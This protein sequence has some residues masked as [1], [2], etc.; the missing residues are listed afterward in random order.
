MSVDASHQNRYD[1]FADQYAQYVADKEHEPF[2]FYHD[3]LAPRLF[4]CLSDVAGMTVLD[5]G[6]GEGI[7]PGSWPSEEPR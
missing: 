7:F 6:C 3:L 1:Q 4:V 2:S 5:A